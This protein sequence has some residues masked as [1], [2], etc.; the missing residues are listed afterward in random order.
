MKCRRKFTFM[1]QLIKKLY[2]T[3]FV[4]GFK[5]GGADWGW[6]VNIGKGVVGVSMIQ[7]ALFTG[8]LSLL[9][10]WTGTRFAMSFSKWVY[11]IAFAML[12][13]L[14]RY[15]LITCGYGIEFEREFANLKK[16]RRLVLAC[17]SIAISTIILIFYVYGASVHRDFILRK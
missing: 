2:L 13:L 9:D 1:F 15:V 14:N 16:S 17:L 8:C 12:Y 11:V 5:T 4:L 7:W 3:A 10:V 6:N